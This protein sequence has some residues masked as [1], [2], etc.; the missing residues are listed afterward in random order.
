MF[1][2]LTDQPTDLLGGR[3]HWDEALGRDAYLDDDQY[4]GVIFPMEE[5][6]LSS[7]N[8]SISVS[9]SP[10]FT[11]GILSRGPPA[12]LGGRGPLEP[13]ICTSLTQVCTV[14]QKQSMHII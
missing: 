2:Q 9:F 14:K 8:N 7:L 13:R 1:D 11:R 6:S 3:L 4:G 5:N 10:L 12:C